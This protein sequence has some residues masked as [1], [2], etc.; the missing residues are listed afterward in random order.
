M[1]ACIG[2]AFAWQGGRIAIAM[3]LQNL[4]LRTSDPS[5]VM[6]Y[7]QTLTIKRFGFSFHAALRDGLDPIDLERQLWGGRQPHKHDVKDKMV[8]EV[9]LASRPL[10]SR[11]FLLKPFARLPELRAS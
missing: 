11:V 6:K 9:S 3:I 10:Y 5:Y 8:K 4:D 7:R 2:R 1:R